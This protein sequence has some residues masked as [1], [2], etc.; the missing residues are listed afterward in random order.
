VKLEAVHLA[1]QVARFE[2]E[3]SRSLAALLESDF[4]A[5]EQLAC[6]LELYR[7]R[8]IAQPRRGQGDVHLG[9]PV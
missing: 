5:A 2:L 6:T 4:R 3:L 8:A 9:A 7:Q 1:P